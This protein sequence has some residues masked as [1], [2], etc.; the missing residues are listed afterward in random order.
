MNPRTR[1]G[2]RLITFHMISLGC[3]K[4]LVDSEKMM[5]SLALSGMALVD[6]PEAAD[7]LIVNT[8][9]FIQ[10]ARDESY[11]VLAEQ[12][13]LKARH[14]GQQVIV[15]GCMVEQHRHEMLKRLPG[16][17]AA[18][19][20]SE[21]DT[22]PEVIRD[23]LSLPHNGRPVENGAFAPRLLATP[24]HMAYLQISDGCF[25]QCSFCTIPRI[26]GKLR[27]R[28][29]EE[30]LAE[31]RSLAEGGAR[32]LVIIAQD[33]TS[34]GFD[35]Y[36]EFRLVDLLEAMEEIDG[37]KWIRLMYTYPTLVDRRLIQHFR[38]S[39]KL[40]SYIDLP[41]QHGDPE[42]LSAMRRGSTTDH[43][44]KVID[45]LR[46][47]RR[48]I[49]LRTSVIVGFPGETQAHFD[50]LI[51]FLDRCKFDRVGVFPYS[52]EEGTPA[53]SLPNRVPPE[54]QAE[55][56]AH[57]LDWAADQALRR[58]R[59]QQGSVLRVLVD[60]RDP[61]DRRYWWGRWEGQAPEVDGRVRLRGHHI[62]PGQFVPV[63]IT[64]VDEDNLYGIRVDP[65]QS[66]ATK[67]DARE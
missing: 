42:I 58:H 7:V 33:S 45:R 20:L 47:A 32:E 10:S 22:I 2:N 8:C 31:A 15:T 9:G 66:S 26:R 51:Q 65:S 53:V 55:R 39:H 37:L 41:V 21:E 40:C 64:A 24:P 35:L 13:D 27:S 62:R 34:Y 12:I 57:L 14:P 5:A 19:N 28:P 43:L 54:V 6:D 52:Y 61:E 1:I 18:L 23:L 38:Q 36:G 50:N 56:V 46:E 60:H 17:D 11:A 67:G 3:P 63:R 29:I 16:I 59:R 30:I 4:N 48:G 25:H 44:L 49:T